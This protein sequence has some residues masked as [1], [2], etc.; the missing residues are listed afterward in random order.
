VSPASH[1]LPAYSQVFLD[2]S[3]PVID[4]LKDTGRVAEIDAQGDMDEVFA[5]VQ[6]TMEVLQDKGE[7]YGSLKGARNTRYAFLNWDRGIWE[8]LL[9]S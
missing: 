2:E 5:V 9:T 6:Q 4:A 3:Q 8:C 1:G 7:A